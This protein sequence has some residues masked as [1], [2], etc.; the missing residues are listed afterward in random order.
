MTLLILYYVSYRLVTL[1]KVTHAPI[2]F[3]VV[4]TGNR[5]KSETDERCQILAILLCKKAL[6]ENTRTK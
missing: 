3:S 1:L 4:Q 6:E 5:K 2:Q